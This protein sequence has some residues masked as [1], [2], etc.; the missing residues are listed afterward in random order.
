MINVL[1]SGANGRMG[2]KV[3]EA[4]AKDESVKA[5]CGVDLLENTTG[6]FKVYS[7]F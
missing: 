4:C 2:K 7:S 6:E 1:I 3:F 5:V